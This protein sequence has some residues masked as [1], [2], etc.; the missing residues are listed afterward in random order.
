MSGL[1]E[2]YDASVEGYF[3]TVRKE[4]L[5]F[6]PRSVNKALEVGCGAGSTL[7]YLKTSGLV[8]YAAG[9]DI[10][11][12]QLEIAKKNGVDFVS[13]IDPLDIKYE[14]VKDDFDIILLLDVLE[15]M[16]DPW[17]A[18]KNITR[19]LTHNGRVILSIPNVQNLRV[20]VPLIFGKWEYKNAGILDKTHLRFFTRKSCVELV[21]QAGMRVISISSNT[22][23]HYLPRIANLFTAKL[24]QRY[25]T[26]QF[27]I[28][29][30][31]S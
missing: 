24:F 25:I 22:E 29:C 27:I 7:V 18:L 3:N 5:P 13:T 9:F 28:V 30:E 23:T 1:E 26:K 12:E 6:I 10:N 31:R 11:S 4:I 17:T 14:F 15:H 2:M 19:H 20:I 21:R 16:I 8:R